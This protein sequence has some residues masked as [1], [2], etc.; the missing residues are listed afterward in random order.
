M[1]EE[2]SPKIL[3][4][5]SLSYTRPLWLPLRKRTEYNIHEDLPANLAIRLRNNSIHA[6]LLSPTDYAR[7]YA[8]YRIVPH[9]GVASKGESGTILLS[10][11]K[12]LKS[13]QTVAVDPSSA[14]EIV[15]CRI[16][17]AEKYNISPSFVPVNTKLPR[18]RPQQTRH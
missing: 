18:S 5:P 17:L 10:F 2:Q 4:V 9:A 12:G 6:A 14:S 15:L 7:D 8:M 11:T 13:I 16:V 1:S 3:G